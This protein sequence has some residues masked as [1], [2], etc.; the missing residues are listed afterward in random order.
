MSFCLG[1]FKWF[2]SNVHFSHNATLHTITQEGNRI[3]FDARQG[4]NQHITLLF[5]RQSWEVRG[6]D[7]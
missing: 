5:S 6:L 2:Q 3:L 7:T 4:E 1:Y